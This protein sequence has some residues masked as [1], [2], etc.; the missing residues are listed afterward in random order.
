M[1]ETMRSS[2]DWPSKVTNTLVGYVDR[3]R[4]ASTGK[5]LTISRM[6][7]YLLAIGLTAIVA[8]FVALILLVRLMVSI[9]ATFAVDEGETWLAYLILGVVFWIV[10]AFFWR[11]KGA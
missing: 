3:V 1:S 5:A 7:V 8:L 2:D 9:T 4:G 6:A 10:G 11:K